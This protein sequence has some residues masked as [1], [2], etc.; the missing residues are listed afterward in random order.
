MTALASF[1]WIETN[2]LGFL[3]VS[4][5]LAANRS[6]VRLLPGQHGRERDT[7]DSARD[8]SCVCYL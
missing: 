7:A 1:P 8:I 6:S 4:N 2:I 3:G 5:D